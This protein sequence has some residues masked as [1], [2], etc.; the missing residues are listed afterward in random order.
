M[1]IRLT[2]PH[3]GHDFDVVPV[4][5]HRRGVAWLDVAAQDDIASTSIIVILVHL[6][7]LDAVQ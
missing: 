4:S 7:Q 3:H 6:V 1:P 5:H 2:R